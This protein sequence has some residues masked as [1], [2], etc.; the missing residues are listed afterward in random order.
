MRPVNTR[1]TGKLTLLTSMRVQ[2]GPC[3]LTLRARRTA[4]PM[5]LKA[6]QKTRFLIRY[7]RGVPIRRYIQP[8]Q[9][10]GLFAI[11]SAARLEHTFP[12]GFAEASSKQTQSH[13]LWLSCGRSSAG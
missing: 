13:A 6:S 11:A 9:S 3:M 12:T 8:S 5:S 2:R 1:S 7:N 10:V 4:A